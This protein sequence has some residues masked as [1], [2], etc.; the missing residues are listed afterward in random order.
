VTGRMSLAELQRELGVTFAYRYHMIN[1][2]AKFASFLTHFFMFLLTSLLEWYLDS[3]GSGLQKSL[4]VK[5]FS[6][7]TIA[8]HL[9]HTIKFM[10]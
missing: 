4:W 8:A 10:V 1:H 5:C 2:C 7:S 9:D 6:R 3:I